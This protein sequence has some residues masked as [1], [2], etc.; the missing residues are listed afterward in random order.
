M[1]V[2]I[3]VGEASRIL[4]VSQTAVHRMRL[5]HY[6]VAMRTKPFRFALSDVERR[7]AERVGKKKRGTRS[8]NVEL[9]REGN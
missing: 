3:G 6:L 4:D 7:R 5:R 2:L 8:H 9:V 1:E